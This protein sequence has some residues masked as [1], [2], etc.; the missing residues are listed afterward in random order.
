[1]IVSVTARRRTALLKDPVKVKPHGGVLPRDFECSE[2]S[3]TSQDRESEGRHDVGIGEDKLQ[4]TADHK[5]AVET[6]EKGD[7]VALQT[8]TK[9]FQVYLFIYLFIGRK[10]I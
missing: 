8:K 5:K 6:I 1:M 3:D 10:I 9:I 2:Q 7:K 4:D